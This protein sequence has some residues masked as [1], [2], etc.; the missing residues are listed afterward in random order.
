MVRQ[1]P[2]LTAAERDPND[3]AARLRPCDAVA[4]ALQ[5]NQPA[6]L[7]TEKARSERA[8]TV[9]GLDRRRF[10]FPAICSDWNYAASRVGLL[11]VG[12]GKRAF[13]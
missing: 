9:S 2:V 7:R 12:L 1:R 11:L 6:S 8:R 3:P 5:A 10:V 4:Q 13:H